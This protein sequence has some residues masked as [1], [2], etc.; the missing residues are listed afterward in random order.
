MNTTGSKENLTPSQRITNQITELGGWRGAM[1]A[2][3]RDLIHSAAP[4]LNEEWKWGTAVWSRNGNVLSLAAFKDHVKLTFFKGA[5]LED[6][7]GLINAGLD[8][9]VMR[10]I[11]FREGDKLQEQALRALIQS[12]VA[13]IPSGL[14][15]N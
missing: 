8:A 15:R 2:A 5:S 9:K 11:D 13:S 3:L 4:G 7:Q 10:S 12:A 1:L 14:K 6:P